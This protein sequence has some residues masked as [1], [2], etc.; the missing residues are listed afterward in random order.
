LLGSDTTSGRTAFHEA[1]HGCIA[2][3]CQVPVSFVSIEG[4]WL[5]DAF[6]V[7][8]TAVTFGQMEWDALVLFSLAGGV[9]EQ[10]HLACSR[11]RLG[12]ARDLETVPTVLAGD[13]MLDYIAHGRRC[14]RV[15]DDSPRMIAA[16]D[17]RRGRAERLVDEHWTWITRV[18]EAL[19]RYRAALVRLRNLES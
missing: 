6:G 14:D 4:F 8:Q 3:V 11:T 13:L 12:D 19:E 2:V 17:L 16:V 10:R 15:L 1:G 5:P 9:V 18:A 7:I